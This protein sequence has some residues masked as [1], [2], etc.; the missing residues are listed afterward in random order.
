MRFPLRTKMICWRNSNLSNPLTC[1][2]ASMARTRLSVYGMSIGRTVV[3]AVEPGFPDSMLWL[4][5]STR[6]WRNGK[7]ANARTCSFAVVADRYLV[8]P[9]ATSSHSES[10]E[11]VNRAERDDET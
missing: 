7:V 9:A 1:V 3:D 8:N 2:V 10:W 11:S 4:V 5:A 6:H